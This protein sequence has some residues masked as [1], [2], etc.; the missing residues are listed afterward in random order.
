MYQTFVNI[1]RILFSLTFSTHTHARTYDSHFCELLLILVFVQVLQRNFKTN[2]FTRLCV[3][4]FYAIMYM[5]SSSVAVSSNEIPNEIRVRNGLHSQRFSLS[6][7]RAIVEDLFFPRR[8]IRRRDNSSI[9]SDERQ[10]LT[11]RLHF[12]HVIV[13]ATTAVRNRRGIARCGLRTGSG[14]LRCT[15]EKLKFS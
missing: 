5:Y 13:G 15:G 8:L 14:L 4:R 11:R 10:S 12:R 3:N 1:T 9:N 2:V 7:I 6:Q